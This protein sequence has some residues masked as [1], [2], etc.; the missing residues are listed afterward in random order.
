MSITEPTKQIIIY[1]D[2]DGIET[3]TASKAVTARIFDI[4]EDGDIEGVTTVLINKPTQETERPSTD[5]TEAGWDEQKHQRDPEGRFAGTGGAQAAERP[6]ESKFKQSYENLKQFDE[7]P[8]GLGFESI[9]ISENPTMGQ[10]A[11]AYFVLDR[12]PDMDEGKM[13]QQ[14]V[15][16]DVL[17]QAATATNEATQAQLGTALPFAKVSGRVKSRKSM[18]GKLGKKRKYDTVDQLADISGTRVMTQNIVENEVA[19]EYVRQNFDVVK[20][21]DRIQTPLEGYRAIHFDIR[22]PDGT[23]SEMQVRTANQDKWA[24]KFHDSVYKVEGLPPDQKAAVMANIEQLKQYGQ[25]MS[26]YYYQS[27]LGRVTPMPVCPP[28]VQQVIGCL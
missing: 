24:E 3:E 26:D 15:R 13:L 4:N 1:L 28:M 8:D 19:Q 21:Q 18:L 5:I 12:Y 27:D 16:A 25:Q 23:I 11:T 22:N 6:V 20:E 2:E 9:E 17:R 7:N 14:S 10:Q